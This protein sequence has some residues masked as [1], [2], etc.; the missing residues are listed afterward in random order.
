MNKFLRVLRDMD[1]GMGG[2]QDLNAPAVEQVQQDQGQGEVPPTQQAPD[3]NIVERDKS[4]NQQTWPLSYKGQ[5]V[6]AKDPAH[7]TNLA[8]KGWAFEKNQ[9]TLNARQAQMDQ[10]ATQY[11]KYSKLDQALQ[12]DQNF[13]TAYWQFVNG[14]GQGGN[15]EQQ[16]DAGQEQNPQYSQLQQQFAQQQQVIEQMQT[17]RQQEQAFN[18]DSALEKEM[19]SLKAEFPNH[20]WDADDG[21]G[22]LGQRL[23]Q[24]AHDGG[25]NSMKDAYYL[26]H[27]PQQEAADK[28]RILAGDKSQRQANNRLGIVDGGHNLQQPAQA[29]NHSNH[30]FDQLAKMAISELGE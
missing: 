30:S 13:Q 8:Q 16:I 20:S 17:D 28:S 5:Q 6:Y 21:N 15:Q 27:R 10:Q 4:Y 11:E 1:G 25:H 3:P 29:L 12:G 23:M 14:Y 22:T 26:Y 18:A 2:G 7:L 9:E 24:F 19:G